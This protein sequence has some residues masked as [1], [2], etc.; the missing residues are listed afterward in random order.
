MNGCAVNALAKTALQFL[1]CEACGCSRAL[2]VVSVA[3]WAC[4]LCTAHNLDMGAQQ[5]EVCE[6]PR[7]KDPPHVAALPQVNID[8]VYFA[9]YQ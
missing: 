3:F 7:P 4:P 5:C 6:N 1:E 9:G 8:E 2:A